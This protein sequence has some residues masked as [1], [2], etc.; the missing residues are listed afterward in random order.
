MQTDL[1][2]ADRVRAITVH[3]PFAEFL[4]AL[5]PGGTFRYTYED[6]VKLCGHSCPT[7]ARAWLTTALA[8]EALYG[9]EVPVRGEIEVTVGGAADDGATGPASQVIGLVTGAAADTGFGGLGGRF[10]RQELLRF[11]PAL[12][13]TVRFRRTDTGATADAVWVQGGIPGSPE[14]GALMPAVVSGEA[15][16]AERCRFAELW[17]A[18]VEDLLLG[19]PQRVVTVRVRAAARD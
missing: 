18:R 16:A 8:L 3:E 6:A 9:D 1:A 14:L 5:R 19:D 4:G 13:G 17:Q 7:V 10:R 2:F 15:S 12:R 11:D